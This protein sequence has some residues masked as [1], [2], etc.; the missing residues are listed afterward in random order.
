MNFVSRELSCTQ[1]P[2]KCD[3]IQHLLF[4][5]EKAN[6]KNY[7]LSNFYFS[8]ITEVVSIWK[9]A[10]IPV[11]TKTSIRRKLEFLTKRYQNI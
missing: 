3:I 6:K 1:L 8:T 2:T 7:G 9:S 11:I 10:K 5:R 4:L